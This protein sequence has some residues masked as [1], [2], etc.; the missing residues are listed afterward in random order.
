MEWNRNL[1][2]KKGKAL[3]FDSGEYKNHESVAH[4]SFLVPRNFE[5]ARAVKA[6]HCDKSRLWQSSVHSDTFLIFRMS[7]LSPIIPE[8]EFVRWIEHPLIET[9]WV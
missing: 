4:R 6:T 1:Q 3:D 7:A 9:S 8:A 2:N 5:A